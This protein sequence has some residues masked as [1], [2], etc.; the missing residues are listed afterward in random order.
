MSTSTTD[1]ST[2]DSA[3]S[4]LRG[5]GSNLSTGDDA[6]TTRSQLRSARRVQPSSATRPPTVFAPSTNN[7]VILSSIE[8]SGRVNSAAIA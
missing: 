7:N 1:D 2:V 6:T 3:L 8:R 5:L 4:A